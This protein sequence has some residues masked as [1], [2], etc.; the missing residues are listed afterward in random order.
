MS[1]ILLHR[2]DQVIDVRGSKLE[3][4]F[5]VSRGN[6]SLRNKCYRIGVPLY[7]P[8]GVKFGKNGIGI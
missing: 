1:Y 4:S 7:Q 8:S 3:A 6:I 2:R 5:N